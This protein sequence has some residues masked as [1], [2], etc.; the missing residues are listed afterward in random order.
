MVPYAVIVGPLLFPWLARSLLRWMTCKACDVCDQYVLMLC[1]RGLHVV[2]TFCKLVVCRFVV[3]FYL[4]SI[5]S[6]IRSVGF[7]RVANDVL[8]LLFCYVLRVCE[9]AADWLL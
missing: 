7:L 8:K 3:I 1:K 4:V 6:N 9:R 2:R 5:D